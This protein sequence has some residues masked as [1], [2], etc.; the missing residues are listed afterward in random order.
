M[1]ESAGKALDI[2]FYLA[3]VGEG[4]SL[5]R[6]SKETGMNKATALRYLTVLESKGVVER[7]LAG[8]T[9]G[10]SLFELGSKV[11]V[12]QLVAEKVRP[13]IERLARETGES[14][15][16]AYLAGDTAIYLD[17]AEANRSLRM[18]SMPGDRLPLYC[19]GV[20]KAILSQLT[21]ERIRAILGPGPLPKIT[22]ST[23]T[24]PEDIIHEAMRARELGY[25]VDREEFEIGL[26][27]YAM[28]LRLPGSDF[29][30]A[31][32]ISGPTA[33]MKNPEIRERFLAILRQAVQDATD[34]LSPYHYF[35]N[36]PE[37]RGD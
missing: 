30:G 11:P 22:D 26:T 16:L 24:D 27:C 3:K 35:E 28:P 36:L 7:C 19:T 1:S 5:A 6:L 15:N 20:G 13:I 37:N 33:R 4:V 9:L 32:S 34:M 23:L 14:S 29:V 2:L 21:E 17:R 18:R 8:W 25:G 10:L 12:R 31:I